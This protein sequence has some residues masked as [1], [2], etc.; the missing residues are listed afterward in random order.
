MATAASPETRP[1]SALSASVRGLIGAATAAWPA[2]SARVRRALQRSQ[3]VLASLLAG[4]IDAEGALLFVAASCAIAPAACQV[5]LHWP[6]RY[7]ELIPAAIVGGAFLRDAV[8]RKAATV[9]RSALAWPGP[10]CAVVIAASVVVRGGHDYVWSC[11]RRALPTPSATC[12]TR[13]STVHAPSLTSSPRRAR[14]RPSAWLCSSRN[15]FAAWRR[16]GAWHEC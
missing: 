7:A 5:L 3:E 2:W 16:R 8:N 11:R 13:S 1:R 6:A 14:G 15:D 4:W 9:P 10:A 12:P